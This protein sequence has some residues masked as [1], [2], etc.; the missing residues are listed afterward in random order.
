MVTK[1]CRDK[2]ANAVAQAGLL[3]EDVPESKN[4]DEHLVDAVQHGD[5]SAFR[6]LF[7]AHRAEVHRVVY[8]LLGPSN[9]LEDIIQEVF[10]QVHRSIGN[11]RGQAKFSTWL[12]RVAVN[13]TLQHLRR[14]RATIVSHTD[15]HL[16]ERPGGQSERTPQE[17]AET[18][19][20]LLAVYRA[21]DQLS[22]KKRAVLV[23]HDMQG[24]NAQEIAKVV[25]S[26]VFTVR[27]RL[28]YARREFYKKIIDDPAFSGD[29]S[30]VEL[31]RTR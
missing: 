7:L 30:A 31:A 12:H 29:I 6:D 16:E 20:R 1:S 2:M 21:L 13:V 19:D 23:M 22:P 17:N 24:M 8:R 9:D 4:S 10:I 5:D 15:E 28:F 26:P 25:G 3:Y 14:K 18:Q 11:F 27:T